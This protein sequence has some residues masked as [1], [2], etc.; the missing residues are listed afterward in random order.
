MFSKAAQQRSGIMKDYF[1][2]VNTYS[3]QIVAFGCFISQPDSCNLKNCK[4]KTLTANHKVA[5]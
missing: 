3:G 4:I 1:L 2:D 5:A